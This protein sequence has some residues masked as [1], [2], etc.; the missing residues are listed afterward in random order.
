MT[1]DRQGGAA[2]DAEG[3]SR[4]ADTARRV[5]AIAVAVVAGTMLAAWIAGLEIA[6][7][8]RIGGDEFGAVILHVDEQEARGV[9][10][11]LR[12]AVACVSA[13]LTAGGRRNRL[14]ASV[15]VA[16]LAGE[17]DVESLIDLAD[18]RTYD[19]KRA[20]LRRSRAAPT[21]DSASISWCS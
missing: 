3:G 2:R 18:Q 17:N 19:D 15:G 5:A 6:T 9:A 1:L 20:Q 16:P 8:G 7:V 13:E 10:D 21:T 4:H 11:G 12:E 14:G